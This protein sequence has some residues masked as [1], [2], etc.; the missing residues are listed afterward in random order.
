[1]KV[2]IAG[3]RSIT[4]QALVD[5]VMDELVA[6]GLIF[7]E[8]VCGDAQGV[9]MLGAHWALEHGIPVR[10]F[11]ADWNRLGPGAGFIRNKHMGEYADYFVALWDGVSRGTAHM[12][13]TM[14]RLGK[15]GLV[16]RR[17]P[18]SL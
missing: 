6:S 3:S 1:M 14:R 7:D 16:R 4:E 9:D 13:E 2:I 8:V 11:P 17:P 5:K 12:I 18:Q 15:H 10:H